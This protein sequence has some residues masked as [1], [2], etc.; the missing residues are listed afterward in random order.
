MAAVEAARRH[1]RWADVVILG[2]GL[3]RD[4]ETG[5]FIRELIDG[6]E[7][8]MLIDADG[9]NGVAEEVTLLK[10]RG[11]RETIITPHTGEFSRLTGMASA[12]IERTRSR[13]AG[14]LARRLSLT[15]VLKGAPTLTASEEGP[16]Y[17]NSNGNPG[18]ATAGSGDIL[19]GVIGA[20]WAQG[21]GRAEAAFC[22]VFVHG[23]AGDLS[24]DELG[25]KGMMAMDI[26]RNVPRA[27]LE[28]EGPVQG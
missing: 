11:N 27:L 14:E 18:M 6:C 12:E 15:V 2:P 1:I 28:L 21:L 7:K 3:S 17:V 22:G 8:P 10:R 23:R 4:P 13:A 9:L 16:L 26:C 5:R 19:S 25:E 20:L 24:R